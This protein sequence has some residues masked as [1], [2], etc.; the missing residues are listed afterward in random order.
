MDAPKVLDFHNAYINGDDKKLDWLWCHE[1]PKS[2]IKFSHGKYNSDGSNYF[3]EG[4]QGSTLW[5][6]S[7]RCFNDPFDS[8]INFDYYAETLKLSKEIL[9]KWVGN[10]SAERI[11]QSEKGGELLERCI[12]RIRLEFEENHRVIEKSIYSACFSEFENLYSLRMWGHYAD[13]H[14]GVC[15]EY[16]FKAVNDAC[17]F[18]CIPIRYT[19]S[20]EYL[21]NARNMSESVRN[22]LKLYTKATEWEHEKEWRVSKQLSGGEKIGV[23]IPFV[24]PRKVYLGC[25]VKEKLKSDVMAFCADRDIEIYQMKLK[26]G[27]FCLDYEKI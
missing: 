9:D 13:N 4:I 20:Y 16:D 7:P 15:A 21:I 11:L 25:R 14:S 24:F 23:S 17:E 12:E 27:S 1:T 2:L 18:G 22:F 26:P 10:D 3:L 6:S 5:L 8:V 19:N